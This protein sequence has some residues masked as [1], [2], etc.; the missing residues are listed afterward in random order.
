MTTG[1]WSAEDAKKLR[2]RRRRQKIA[3]FLVPLVLFGACFWAAQS[4][5][6]SEQ[7]EACERVLAETR[8]ALDFL[9]DLILRHIEGEGAPVTQDEF[10]DARNT[11]VGYAYTFSNGSDATWPDEFEQLQLDGFSLFLK[12]GAWARAHSAGEDGP[13]VPWPLDRG[14]LGGIDPVDF[15]GAD[16]PQYTPRQLDGLMQTAYFDFVGDWR[17]ATA[18]CRG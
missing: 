10:A 4:R 16:V 3:N 11:S 1:G 8:P 15:Y 12:A 18:L 9:T 13:P 2:R 17:E 14:D 7:I 5:A 6:L